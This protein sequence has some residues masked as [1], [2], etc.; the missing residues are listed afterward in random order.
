[1][2]SPESLAHWIIE[3]G[4]FDAYGRVQTILLCTESFTLDECK[5]L[6]EVLLGLGIVTTLKV[7]NSAKGTHRIRVSKK[8][9]PLLRELVTP[10]MHYDFMY[11]LGLK[12]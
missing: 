1:M 10:H 11:K 9:M 6:Q 3:D 4:Y 7:R 8:S 5:L 2:F 12:Q